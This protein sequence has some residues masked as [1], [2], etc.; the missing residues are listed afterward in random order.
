MPS[1]GDFFRIDAPRSFVEPWDIWLQTGI[2]QVRHALGADW[3]DLYM[4]APIWRFS[5]SAGIAGPDAMMGIVMPSVDR[6]GREFPLTLMASV[7]VSS[8]LAVQH[9][10]AQVTFSSLENLALSALDDDMT[11]EFLAQQLAQTEVPLVNS[12]VD[13]PSAV[14]EQI[15]SMKRP[16]IWTVDLADGPLSMVCDGLP[17]ASEMRGLFDLNAPIWKTHPQK[18][19]AKA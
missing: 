2:Q 9:F 3:Q 1:L 19:E 8:S 17:D 6:V 11:R 16:S 12:D 13:V 4:S 7:P 5:L 14:A 10:R 18:L 15:D